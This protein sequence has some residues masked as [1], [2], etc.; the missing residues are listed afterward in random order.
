[1]KIRTTASAL[2]VAGA[3]LLTGCGGGDAKPSKGDLVE[4]LSAGIDKA[5]IDT[6]HIACLAD[7]LLDSDISVEALEEIAAATRTWSSARPTPRS[8]PRSSTTARTADLG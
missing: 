5:D 1:M 4:G 2:L 8:P 6:E 7:G 3:V